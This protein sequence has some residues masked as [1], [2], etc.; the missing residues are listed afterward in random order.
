MLKRMKWYFSQ[1]K[2]KELI[3]AAEEGHLDR[4]RTLLAAGVNPN[5][6]VPGGFTPLMWAAARGHVEVVQMLLGAGA[7]SKAQTRKGRTAGDIAVQ[8]GRHDVAALLDKADDP[9]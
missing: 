1:K 5:A 4:V 8:E 9:T 6:R 3:R 2:E 7:H